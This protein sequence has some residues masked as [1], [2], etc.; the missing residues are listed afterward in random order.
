MDQET[1]LLLQFLDQQR[2]RMLGVLDGLRG[3]RFASAGPWKTHAAAGLALAVTYR[4]AG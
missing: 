3:A 4:Q 1:E 2:K